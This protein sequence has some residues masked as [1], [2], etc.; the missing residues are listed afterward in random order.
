MKALI[1][2]L[3]LTANVYSQD[4]TEIKFERITNIEQRLA[5]QLNNIEIITIVCKDTTMR[6]KTF[7]LITEEYK[8]GKLVKTDDYGM[9]CEDRED[10]FEMNGET[11]VHVMNIC[12]RIRFKEKEFE[13]KLDELHKEQVNKVEALIL[14]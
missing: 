5:N 3:L 4:S 13:K 12:N 7:K 2:F 14:L 9:T 6:G 10:K 1:L 8:D 11:V